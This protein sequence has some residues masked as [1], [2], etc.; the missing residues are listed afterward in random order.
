MI[1]TE[2]EHDCE[3]I[4]GSKMWLQIYHKTDVHI[5]VR[6]ETEREITI[7]NGNE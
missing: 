7:C 5:D 4:N 3:I 6:N 1:V 2:E